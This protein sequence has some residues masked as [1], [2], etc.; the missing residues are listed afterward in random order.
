M[1]ITLNTVMTKEFMKAETKPMRWKAVMKLSKDQEGGS[2]KGL[3]IISR[4]LLKALISTRKN[5]DK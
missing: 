5:G 4:L 3:E 1:P 2:P